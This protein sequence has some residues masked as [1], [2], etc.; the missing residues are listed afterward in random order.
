MVSGVLGFFKFEI[1]SKASI[2]F[3]GV[4]LNIFLFYLV[5]VTEI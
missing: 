1:H 2:F 4:C 3:L 5:I